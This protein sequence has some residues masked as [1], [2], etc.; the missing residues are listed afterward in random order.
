LR[1]ID[2]G[3][4]DSKII[5][6]REEEAGSIQDIASLENVKPGKRKAH[7]KHVLTSGLLVV[8]FYLESVRC[9]PLFSLKSV[10]TITRLVQW[11]K[12]YKTA[13]GK[14]LNSLVSEIPSSAMEA[15]Q[16]IETCHT[17][18]QTL[19]NGTSVEG[20]DFFLGRRKV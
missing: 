1:L 12:Y 14:G 17:R 7:K 20:K 15:V 4:S 5:V 8:L 6:I 13:E 11:L 16:I 9:S 3:E 10:G 18:W 2:S 19:K